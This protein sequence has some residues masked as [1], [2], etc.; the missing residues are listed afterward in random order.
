LTI[1]S[2]SENNGVDDEP[3]GE[4]ETESESDGSENFVGLFDL[5][6]IS[7]S[8]EIEPTRP[9]EGYGS[10]GDSE[11]KEE[12][13]HNTAK[14]TN[15]CFKRTVFWAISLST[16]NQPAGK[17]TG[18]ANKSGRRYSGSRLRRTTSLSGFRTRTK[19]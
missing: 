1:N 10:D 17:D 8:G 6:F 14:K 2:E 11:N 16:L 12:E 15:K 7:R 5:A 3:C 9:S 13:I 19:A 18:I 4:S